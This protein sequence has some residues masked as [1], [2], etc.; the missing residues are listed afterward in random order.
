MDIIMHAVQVGMSLSQECDTA[1][2]RDQLLKFLDGDNQTH[3]T[4]GWLKDRLPPEF[5]HVREWW[6]WTA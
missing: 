3:Q 6:E 1:P 2:S 4:L 5:P